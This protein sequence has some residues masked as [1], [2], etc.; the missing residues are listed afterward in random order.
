MTLQNKHMRVLILLENHTYPLDVRVNP[1]AEYLVQSGYDVTVVSPSGKNFKWIE[2]LN[3]VKIFRYPGFFAEKTKI[4]Y[5]LEFILSAVFLTLY[6][7][8]LG[9]FPGFDILFVY[10]P[11]D[12]AWLVGFFP[13]LFG[14]KVFFD[15]RDLS[16]ELFASKFG[17]KKKFILNLLLIMEKLSCK[18]SDHIFVTNETTKRLIIS[19]NNIPELQVSILRQGPDLEK[20][21]PGLP[22][23]DLRASAPVILGYIGNMSP[24]RGICNLLEACHYLAYELGYGN[25]KCILIGK[26]TSACDLLQFAESLNIADHI[27]FTGF[28]LPDQWIPKLRAV[29]ICIDPGSSNPGN[30]TSTTNKMMDYMALSKPLVVFDLPERH[31][32]A[33]ESALY[34][35]INDNFDLA[36]KIAILIDS[37][38]LRQLMGKIG[39]QRIQTT[40][41]W[42]YQRNILLHAFSRITEG[43]GYES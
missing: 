17:N 35:H 7:S 10:N 29:D 40:Y 33:G 14:K 32:T 4:G 38:D 37:P 28:L 5:F 11:P 26:Q 24:E 42:Q 27:I 15:L 41:A 39:L 34:A 43:D 18:I 20:I 19:R 16:P 2:V 36:K 8:I 25:W 6:S 30:D 31:V 13:K 12:I 22:D 21:K 1:H 23:E 9:L 3:G